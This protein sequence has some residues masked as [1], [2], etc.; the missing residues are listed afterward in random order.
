MYEAEEVAR[1]DDEDQL[2]RRHLEARLQRE[3]ERHRH[4]QQYPH[5]RVVVGV[6]G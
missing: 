5:R 3:G 2:A 1:V 4:K 6:V